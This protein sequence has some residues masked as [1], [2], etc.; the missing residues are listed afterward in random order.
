MKKKVILITGASRGLGLALARHWCSENTVINM[1]RTQGEDLGPSVFFFQCDLSKIE[2]IKVTISNVIKAFPRIDLVINNAGIMTSIPVAVMDPQ[3]ISDMI[4]VNLKAPMVI[5]RYMIR[6]MMRVK[7][8]QIINILS[9]A[10]GLN[11]VGDSVYGA[12]KA[13]LETFSKTLNREGHPV[14]VHVNNISISGFPSGMLDNI[15]LKDKNKILDLIPHKQ[16]APLSEIIQTI[17]FFEKNSLDIGGQT[18]AF[19]GI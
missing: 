14:G 12:T 6:H 10:S 16:Y 8:G 17:E 13:G 5:S 7:S 11:I 18:I 15:I 19:G 1:S 3:V 2:Q 4:D 9:M